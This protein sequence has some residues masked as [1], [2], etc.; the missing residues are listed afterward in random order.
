MVIANNNAFLKIV[1]LQEVVLL[2][3]DTDRQDEKYEVMIEEILKKY[4]N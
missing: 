3:G 4:Q 2:D 1:W